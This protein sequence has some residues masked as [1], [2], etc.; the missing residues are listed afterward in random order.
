MNAD[1]VPFV[2]RLPRPLTTSYGVLRERRGFFVRRDSAC[3]E[4]TPLP[5]FGTEDLA[6]CE[7]VLRGESDAFA[8]CA[9]H[10]LEQ[11]EL[12]LELARTD[13]DTATQL[14]ARA[15]VRSLASDVV[16]S[17]LAGRDLMERD[18]DRVVKVKVV[19]ADETLATVRALK[20][21]L[22][23]RL[24]CNGAL[25]EPQARAFLRAIRD[26]DNVELVEQPVA[27]ADVDAL[28]AL[29]R[30]ARVTVAADEALVDPRARDRLLRDEAPLAFI[31]KPQAVGGATVVIDG[32]K[33]LPER[34][35]IVTGFLDTAVARRLAHA[36][37]RVVDALTGARRAHGLDA[38]AVVV[39]P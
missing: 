5:A 19:D 23:L 26:D 28:C 20:G 25:D 34:V 22:R 30:D 24:D 14:A 37:A 13:T 9:R 29:A 7:A 15:G 10:A 4:A 8:P 33:R 11:L 1:V 2:A 18:T 3:G 17:V 38:L 35:H 21:R 32:V 6:T 31:W 36:T 39:D 27:A 12:E 16:T